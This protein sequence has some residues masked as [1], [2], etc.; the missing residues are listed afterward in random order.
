MVSSYEYKPQLAR[1][2]TAKPPLRWPQYDELLAWWLY[3]CGP[4]ASPER[5]FEILENF[6]SIGPIEVHARLY[7][8]YQGYRNQF[9]ALA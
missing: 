5:A 6:N 8:A 3:H 9:A 2:V 7:A 1:R 4:A